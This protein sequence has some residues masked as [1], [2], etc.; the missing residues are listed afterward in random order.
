M[1]PVSQAVLL[2]WSIPPA[3]SFALALTAVVYLR[4]WFL[5]RRAG[6]PFV[7]FWRACSFLLGILALWA[8][9]A[10]PLDT[11]SSFVLTAH[12]LQHMV[13]MMLAPPLILLGAP[14]VPLM[15]G[16]PIFAAREFAG[17]FVNW[18]AA[19]RIG[20]AL[21]HPMVA[22][23][24]MGAVTF[25]WH[26][27]RLYELALAS[28][29][30][31]EVEHAC[32][33]L[34]SLIFWWPVIRPWPSQTRWP[35]WMLVPYLMVADLENTILSAILVFSDK[36]LYPSYSTM[37]RLFD[38]SAVQD[39]SAAGA[40]MWV[41]GSLVFVIPAT[42]VAMQCLQGKRQKADLAATRKWESPS[43]D[44]LFVIAERLSVFG[45]VLKRKFGGRRVEA[46]SFV[47][48]FAL[49]SL[50]LAGL[51]SSAADDDDQVIRLRQ[52]AGPFALTVFAPAGDLETGPS[53]FNL[54]VQDRKTQ[55]VLQDASVNILATPAT[56]SRDAKEVRGLPDESE[57]KLLQASVLNL[58]S[59]GDWTL[60][61]AVRRGAEQASFSLP[62]RVMKPDS[63][64]SI[65]WPYLFLLGFS[66]LLLFTYFWRHRIPRSSQPSH[67][68]A[69]EGSA[70]DLS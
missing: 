1:Q 59:E 38:F 11:F 35:L 58:P 22:L 31:H 3:A 46:L 36:G 50:C 45:T 54:L 7:P 52:Q 28:S 13:L 14:L 6:V 64:I 61:I 60:A 40:I 23:L 37:P 70:A 26:T 66:A 2:S 15:R 32:F 9:L 12:M 24:L 4:G 29:S 57:N 47:A 51:A 41:L 56:T 34:V 69:K 25:A 21:T 67:S 42:I 68:L 19:N 5:M 10:S 20:A 33:F 43:L 53:N 65:S 18:R 49:A 63:G 17:P 8:A 55:E 39:Q 30:W 27:P 44:R 48:L 16:M 62:V